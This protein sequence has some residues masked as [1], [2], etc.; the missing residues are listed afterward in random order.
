MN[1]RDFEY[2]AE[3]GRSESILKASKNLYISQPALS[4]FLQKT[5]T[6]IGTLLFQR[7][8]HRLV[9]TYAGEQCIKTAEEILFLHK[10]LAN[11]LADITRQE[12]GLIRLGLPLSRGNYFLTELLPRFHQEYPHICVNLFEDSTVILQRMLRTG[13]LDIIFANV[14]E[15]Y[16]DLNYIPISQ[17]EMV[18][19]AP[20]AFRLREK[21]V[22]DSAYRYPC[23]RPEDWQ[24]LP[25]LA[26]SGDQMSRTFA[27]QYLSHHHITPHTILI[28]RNLAQVLSCVRQGLG[29][30][31]CPA[32][33]LEPGSGGET[34]EYYSLRSDTGP[35]L[36]Q[37]AVFFRKDAYLPV[38]AKI[39]I[40]IIKDYYGK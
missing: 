9:P 4:R 31:I 36:R 5:E 37:T 35:V 12:S 29:V 16:D 7:V 10:Q 24:D 20:A 39:L 2:I 1:V 34:A 18:L 26:L 3:L 15:Q 27:D 19:A 21:A 6:E 17:E 8:G 33:P 14:V 23:L 28:I 32:L 30:T 40:Q 13:E 25:F 22:E 11:T 38:P